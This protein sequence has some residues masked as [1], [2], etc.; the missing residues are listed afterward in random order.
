ME[1]T[2]RREA[3]RRPLSVA[4]PL[5]FLQ[6]RRAE[7]RRIR[8]VLRGTAFGLPADDFVTLLEA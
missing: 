1:L 4:V 6:D 5:S 3:R 8:L 2:L 7:M